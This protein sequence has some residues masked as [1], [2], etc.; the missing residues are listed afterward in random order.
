MIRLRPEYADLGSLAATVRS[1]L[2]HSHSSYL[3][4][5]GTPIPMSHPNRWQWS[6]LFAGVILLCAR[7]RLLARHSTN[8][9][10]KRRK[11]IDPTHSLLVRDS[12][13]SCQKYINTLLAIIRRSECLVTLAEA[14]TA[15]MTRWDRT[16]DQLPCRLLMAGR[17][18]TEQHADRNTVPRVASIDCMCGTKGTAGVACCVP[19]TALLLAY[20]RHQTPSVLLQLELARVF[21]KSNPY[22]LL[23]RAG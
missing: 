11:A 8:C 13:P 12:T 21:R 17:S 15:I 23:S 16:H 4:A 1:Y 7:R 22:C 5:F 10:Q 20:G 19:A 9:C 14:K 18:P 2:S 6:G 3:A